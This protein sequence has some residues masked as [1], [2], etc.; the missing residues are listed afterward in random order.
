[1]YLNGLHADIA[2]RPEPDGPASAAA[3]TSHRLI[4]IGPV[5]IGTVAAL[6]LDCTR[7]AD[8]NLACNDDDTPAPAARGAIA[9]TTCVAS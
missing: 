4:V 2:S 3:S 6:S 9:S 5:T 7:S 8:L 1:V